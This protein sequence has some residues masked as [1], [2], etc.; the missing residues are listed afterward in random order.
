MARRDGACDKAFGVV[1]LLR[2]LPEDQAYELLRTLRTDP[3]SMGFGAIRQQSLL[4][5][6]FLASLIRPPQ[7]DAGLALAFNHPAV[8]PAPV[9]LASTTG[10]LLRL[11]EPT[12][13][14]SPTPAP[15]P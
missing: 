14:A 13:L 9:S 10:P 6:P 3:A 7:F 2:T 1:D 5:P 15:A 4:P 8:Y 11:L 12:S